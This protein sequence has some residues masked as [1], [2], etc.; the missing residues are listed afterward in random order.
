MVF[1]SL[2]FIYLFL[3]L[4]L[5]L[6][7]LVKNATWRNVVLVIFSLFFYAWGEPLW[8]ILL[9]ITAVL[10]YAMGL[11]IDKYRNTKKSKTAF[12][13]ALVISLGFL[14]AFKYIDMLIGTL[15]SLLGIEIPFLNF[16]LPIGISFYTFQILSYVIDVYKNEVPV[17]RS[18]LKFIL[19]VSLFP[20]LVAGPILRYGELEKQLGARKITVKG[21]TYG[22][23]RFCVGL[24]KKVLLAN[25][26]GELAT[27]F[28][29]GNAAT[30]STLGA[31]LG[32]IAYTL[33]IY[34]DFSGYSD[35]AIGMG[36]MFGFHYG[37][38]FN[39]PYISTSITEF[40]RRWHI[41]LSTFF[42]DYVYIPLG[43]NRA[44]QV[45]NLFIVWALTGLWHGASWNFVV[46]GL[47]YFALLVLEKFVLGKGLKKAPKIVGWVY[48]IF[49]IMIGWLLFYYT[50]L[51]RGVQTL[52]ILFGIGGIGAT[53]FQSELLFLNNIF[54]FIVA[55]I[56]C[57]PIAK[58][59]RL[60][61]NRL[62]RGTHR[63]RNT[64]LI[65]NAVFNTALLFMST[66]MLI[67]QSF[68]P[69]LYF[70]F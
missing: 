34:F 45:R 50:D 40:W 31:W 5:L 53:D 30:M 3:P 13:V 10:N 9:I 11:L 64:A 62:E 42:R 29:D 26:A 55:I 12:M 20:Q 18:F 44:H 21:L 17:Q 49:F 43:G 60:I 66:A 35:M 63:Q 58:Y 65:I 16:G 38:N 37:E 25:T 8:V 19:F 4:C 27:Y 1:S 22:I 48:S 59:V 28:L 41:S 57:I 56:A 7:F 32:I 52:G 23:T 39:Y 33:Q 69:F 54:F 47:Y 46:W 15:N 67:G 36:H 68:N 70:R 2:F 6:Y 51:S 14:A 24:G 61:W